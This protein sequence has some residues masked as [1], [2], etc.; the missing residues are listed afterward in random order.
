MIMPDEEERL[1]DI[2]NDVLS[3]EDRDNIRAFKL[4]LMAN[5]PR[6]AFDQM[7]YSF[8]H[9][10]DI[11]SDWVITH[12]LAILTRVEPEWYH[13]CVNTCLAY[14]GPNS[15]LLQCQ[16]CN[17]PRFTAKNKPRRL[18]CYIPIIRRLQAYFAN[19]KMSERL[20]YRHNY[21]HVTNTIAD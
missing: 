5:M 18:F 10:L 14:I 9:K 15:D 13:C 7:R 17:E 11:S 4:K 16:T 12:R 3:E 2:R 20:L 1:W 6:T 19:P 21:T 8:N